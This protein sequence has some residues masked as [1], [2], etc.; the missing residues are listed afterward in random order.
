MDPLSDILSVLRPQSYVSAGFDAAG[1][2]SVAFRD[3]RGFL[4][5]YGVVSGAC[6]LSV[7]GV[8]KPVRLEAGEAFVLPTGRDFQLSSDLSLPSTDAAKIIPPGRSGGV[9]TL[10]GG[11]EVFLIGSRFAVQGIEAG[12]L[13]AGLPPI[14][15]L[16]GEADRTALRLSV[17]QMMD[18]LSAARPGASLIAE[19]LAHMML[20]QALRAH[21]EQTPESQGWLYALA[22]RHISAALTAIHAAPARKWTL[23]RLAGEAGMSRSGFAQRFRETV[24]ETP[25]GYL[26]R[27]RMFS[28]VARHQRQPEP[29]ANLAQ[30]AGYN[31]E[32][33]FSTAFRRVMGRS[34]RSY[35]RD[36]G[37]IGDQV[38]GF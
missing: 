29:L 1:P 8:E 25:I 27:W 17:G 13:L 36:S 30:E 38:V 12:M 2:W 37:R 16:H 6:W 15:H 7:S 31:S 4:K 3:Q 9:V 19:H 23:E 18:E 28:A 34:F 35:I 21:L 5:C 14:I 10:N 33:A 11:G 24:G 32:A 26:T 22:D 20:V